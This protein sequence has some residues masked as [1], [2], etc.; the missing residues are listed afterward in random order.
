MRSGLLRAYIRIYAYGV[1]F[2]QLGINDNLR[3]GTVE[4]VFFVSS[5]KNNN[6]TWDGPGNVG[7]NLMHAVIHF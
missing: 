6:A 1:G 2:S 5:K 7:V 3:W 4:K